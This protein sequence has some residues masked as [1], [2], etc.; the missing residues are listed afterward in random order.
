M[1]AGF[2]IRKIG[3]YAIAGAIL[4]QLVPGWLGL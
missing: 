2:D 4:W 1:L 3:G